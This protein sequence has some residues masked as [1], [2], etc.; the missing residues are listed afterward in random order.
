MNFN[1]Q[2]DLYMLCKSNICWGSHANQ[3]AMGLKTF[4]SRRPK[5]P[6]QAV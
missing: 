3:L 2:N 4:F 1:Q 5:S 6:V